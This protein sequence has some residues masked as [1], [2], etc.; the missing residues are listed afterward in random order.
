MSKIPKG[1]WVEVERSLFCSD[2][3][4]ASRPLD[5]AKVP[6]TPWGGEYRYTT[7]G[8]KNKGQDFE[9][10]CDGPDGTKYSNLAN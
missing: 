10:S 7:G 6:L 9:I 8:G 1:T 2:R 5:P 4:V 3:T